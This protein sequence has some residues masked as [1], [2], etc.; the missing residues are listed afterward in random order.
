MNPLIQLQKFI[1]DLLTYNEQLIK[2]GRTNFEEADF[3]TAYIVV[4]VLGESTPITRSESFDDVAEVMTYARRFRIP[5]TVDFYGNETTAHSNAQRFMLLLSSQ[6]ASDLQYQHG[7]TVHAPSGI[8]DVKNLTG[9]Q[10]GERL[11]ISVVLHYNAVETV[12]TLRIDTAQ[13]EF[14]QG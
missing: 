4:D 1:R 8:T 12:N 3:E 7:I 10:Y 11:Q 6:L 13:L 9:Q 14:K 2:R 5:A